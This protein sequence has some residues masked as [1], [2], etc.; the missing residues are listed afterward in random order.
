MTLMRTGRLVA[1]SIALLLSMHLSTAAL[2]QLSEG[3]NEPGAVFN[4]PAFGTP[5]WTDPA[6]AQTSDN[7]DAS[8]APGVNNTQ[9]LH[10]NNFGFA[11][12]A[13]AVIV[14]IE[15]N[16]ERRAATGL[17]L[18]DTRV[19]IVKN[20]VVGATERGDLVTLWPTVDTVKT[21]GSNSDLW[22]ETWTASDI[23]A[24]NFGVVLSV[25]GTGDAAFVD[26]ITATVHYELCTQTPQGVCRAATKSL[27]LVKDNASDDT[28][29][30]TI[31]KWIKGDA[32]SQ[33]E[34]ANPTSTAVYAVCVYENGALSYSMII[35]PG[36]SEWAQI[37]TK[38]FKYKDLTGT[39][40]GIQKIILKGSPDPAKS[41]V[42]VKGRGL[43]LPDPVPALTMPVEVQVINSD[44]GLCWGAEFTTFK[45]NQTGLFKAKNP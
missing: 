5:L 21:Y 7:A 36:T 41:K 1:A 26:S 37:S 12:P 18:K 39:A 38:G 27:F 29:D 24:S 16:I 6:N 19:R 3:P 32:T 28:K 40:Q 35:P 30:K 14:G 15:V 23:N 44:S 2:A 20:G 22:G 17:A 33:T 45:K 25:N 4:D 8:A 42:L 34:F 10:A 43:N 11:I 31:F 13:P 9:Y